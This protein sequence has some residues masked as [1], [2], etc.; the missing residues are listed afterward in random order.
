[1]GSVGTHDFNFIALERMQGTGVVVLHVIIILFKNYHYT[2]SITQ[3]PN[4]IYDD[5]LMNLLKIPDTPLKRPA[6]LKLG[7][8]FF[9]IEKRK[10]YDFNALFKLYVVI[11]F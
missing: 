2:L 1:M 4:K 10:S 6:I 3:K 8:T 9:M 7:Y 11:G 5:T